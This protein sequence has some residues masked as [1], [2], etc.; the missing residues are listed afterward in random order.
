[1]HA[2]PMPGLLSTISSPWLVAFGENIGSTLLVC[3]CN[4]ATSA[5]N[6]PEPHWSVLKREMDQLS[7]LSHQQSA[8]WSIY[9]HYFIKAASIWYNLSKILSPFSL[10]MQVQAPKYGFL[11]NIST[12][13]VTLDINNYYATKT[14]FP[15]ILAAIKSTLQ[16][17]SI[18]REQKGGM[19]CG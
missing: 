14:S 18:W 15:L 11:L 4:P 2:G 6:L 13:Q 3:T 7:E 12:S 8:V 19:S 1:M 10:K 5:S 9:G 17:W 16:D